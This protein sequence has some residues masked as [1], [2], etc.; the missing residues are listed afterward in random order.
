[1]T[2]FPFAITPCCVVRPPRLPQDGVTPLLL[3]VRNGRTRCVRALLA[4]GADPLARHGQVRLPPARPS[5]PAFQI[6]EPCGSC[7]LT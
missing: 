3:A 7:A 1:M 2:S 6:G 4:A 5:A